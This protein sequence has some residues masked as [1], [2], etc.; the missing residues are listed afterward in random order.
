M[1]VI[2][3]MS[4]IAYE[5]WP[6]LPEVVL[7]CVYKYKSLWTIFIDNVAFELIDALYVR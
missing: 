3:R 4:G 6:V 5:A 2:K 1:F 7:W